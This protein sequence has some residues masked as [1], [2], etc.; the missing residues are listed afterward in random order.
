MKKET[1]IFKILSL[2]LILCSLLVPMF[3]LFPEGLM[4]SEDSWSVIETFGTFAEE[5]LDAFWH[6]GVAFHFSVW[7]PGV[8]LCIGAHTQQRKTVLFSSIFGIVILLAVLC[9]TIINTGEIDLIHPT[10]GHI[11]I[12]YW[13]DL[14]LFAICASCSVRKQPE[15]Y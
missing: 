3:N 15:N 8:I 14:I 10:D 6:I 4:P 5:G 13:I 7:V 9:F 2:I 12:G 11:C 1:N